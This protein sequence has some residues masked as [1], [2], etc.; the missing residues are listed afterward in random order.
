MRDGGLYVRFAALQLASLIGMSICNA[1]PPASEGPSSA[2]QPRMSGLANT[3]MSPAFRARSDAL[4]ARSRLDLRAPNITTSADRYVPTPTAE[5]GGKGNLN[6]P[7]FHVSMEKPK[8]SAEALVS[9]ARREGLPVA[10]LWE[11]NA[12]LL[13]LGFNQKGQAGLWLI[14]KYP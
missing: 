10:R 7:A 11:N 9:R 2:L 13:S 12:A 6:A 1:S 3:M 5:H 4:S 8:S 14:K